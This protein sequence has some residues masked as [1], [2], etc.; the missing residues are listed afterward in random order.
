[1]SVADLSPVKVRVYGVIHVDV[2][3]DLVAYFNAVPVSRRGGYWAMSP[4]DMRD[5]G[6]DLDWERPL[7]YLINHLDDDAGMLR[8]S[9][10]GIRDH[11][12]SGIDWESV[13]WTEA[14]YNRLIAMVPWMR[15]LDL[16]PPDEDALEQALKRRP[17]PHD[18]P[19]P[20]L[21]DVKVRDG[22]L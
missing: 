10:P 8:L 4:R 13:D 14:D 16:D 20:G 17:G 19:L 9:G 15:P 21:E 18:V 22:L 2:E 3:A 12:D 6:F 5:W 11:S 7:V 1:M